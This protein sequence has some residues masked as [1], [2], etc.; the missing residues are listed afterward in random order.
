[1]LPIEIQ[2]DVLERMTS[3]AEADFPNECC[4]FFYGA[5]E[6]YGNWKTPTATQTWSTS[7]VASWVGKNTLT[8]RSPAIERSLARSMN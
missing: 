3:H 5:E 8:R 2:P 6:H 7:K 1:M 4:G